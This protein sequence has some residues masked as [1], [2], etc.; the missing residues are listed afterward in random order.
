M[1]KY[2]KKN[3][4]SLNPLDANICLLGLPKIGKEQP[5]SEPILTEYGWM[6]MGSIVPG[7]KVY[8]EDGKLY[9][10]TNVFPQ[11]VKDVYKVT[12]RDGTYTR[13]GLDHLWNVSTIK[14]RQNMR[15]HNDV[16]FKVLTLRDI[17]KDYKSVTSNGITRYKYS[18]PINK[19]IE[20]V[21]NEA[22]EIDPYILGLL[23]G[24][25]G[26]TENCITFT[27]P[28]EDL[29]K[30][31]ETY[32]IEEGFE[33]MLNDRKEELG[34][35]RQYRIISSD[36]DEN[37]FMRSIDYL[38]LKGLDSR[39]KFIPKEYLTSS[40]K[41]RI[42]LLSGIINT[43][44]SIQNKM[45][46]VA[47][48]S[49]MI[50]EDVAELARSLGFVAT[51]H[52][53]DRTNENST[54]KYDK[55]IEYRVNIIGDYSILHLSKKH[56][57]K[58]CTRSIDY[59]KSIVDIE[60]VGKEE[61]QCI[62]VDN[63]NHMY[64]TKD[65]IVTHN[66]TIMK[67]IAE[68]LV[69]DN[70]LFL[71]M[72]RENGAKYI[73]DI[74]YENVPDWDTFVDIIDDIVE[75][76]TTDYPDLKVVFI[77]T[78]DNAIQL[79]EQESIRLWNRENPSKRTDA[80]N[81]AWG[82]FQKGQDKAIDLL[83]EQ[84][85]RLRDVGVAFSLLGH[86]RQTTVTDPITLDTYQQITSDVSQRYFNQIKKNID[87]IGIAYIDREITKE[88]TGQKNI[89]TGKEK[90]INKIASEVR[91]IKFRDSNYCVDSGGRMSEIIEEINFD[92]DEFIKAMR[93]ALEAEVKKAGKS[94]ETRKKE[95]SAAEEVRMKQIA[96]VEAANKIK[97]EL[98]EIN[99]KIKEFCTVNKG[100]RE[101]LMP[102]MEAAKKHN[103]K[104]P[105]LAEDINTAKEILSAIA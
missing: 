101:K 34:L 83:Q 28:E 63:P 15:K 42:S 72:Y 2:G 29:Q 84:W 9:S 16:R 74:V 103:L 96:E 25:G 6:E 35:C 52:K 67:Q 82:G 40:I 94:I 14:Q 65:F 5:V 27:N 51:T 88:K 62:M 71:E 93:D 98:D 55:E 18:I 38:G 39:N 1:G 61:S 77:D 10:V 23:L 17:L 3:H 20:Y 73:E 11:G 102:L 24:D 12:F 89:V 85:F 37:E 79:A 56:T 81:A 8:G 87:L 54:K 100:N 47:T 50:C 95:D 59:V 57:E 90:E 48:Y 99:L 13:C 26:F 64:I 22:L 104:N 68:K 70:Y 58:I 60:F 46:S 33:Y 91:K 32:V 45:I 31:F 97:K 78:I 7:I 80:I 105:M 30:E 49:K 41:D 92:P 19:A 86:V 44:G 21:N 69:G 36:P 4:V 43:D 76:K 75:N 66:T 53:Y